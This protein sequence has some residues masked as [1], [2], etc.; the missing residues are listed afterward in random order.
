MGGLQNTLRTT[1]DDHGPIALGMFS[2]ADA[3]CHTDPV[4]ALGLS[5][6]FIHAKALA[7]TITDHPSDLASAAAAFDAAIRPDL[8]ERFRF[9]SALDSQRARRWAG[10]PVDIAHADGGA[11]ELF[12]YAAGS[13]ASLVDPAIFRFVVRRNT[14]LDSLERLDKDAA[15]QLAIETR[16]AEVSTQARPGLPSRE[17]FTEMV[18][19]AASVSR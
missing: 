11:Y 16:F 8:E 18:V 3:V 10:E 14:L 1:V 13:A 17:D 15:M 6:C 12:S 9:A 7:A 2:V 19:N 4:L 5:F